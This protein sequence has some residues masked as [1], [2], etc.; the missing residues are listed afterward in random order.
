MLGKNITIKGTFTAIL[1]VTLGF[2]QVS[3]EI[4]NVDLSAGIL[5]IYM[6]NT[7]GC[8][9]CADSTY[10]N[11]S[12][13][14]WTW[15]DKKNYCELSSG[16]DTTWVSYEPITEEECSAIPSLTGNGGW[17]FNGEVGGF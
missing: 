3:L 17:W 10:N 11:N 1:F 12:D 13:T 9:Y 15:I 4:K 5:D 2:T 7:A 8:S 6:T 16:G 14:D